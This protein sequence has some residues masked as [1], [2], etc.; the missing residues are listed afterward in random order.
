LGISLLRIV[1]LSI[2]PLFPCGVGAP[3]CTA[4]EFWVSF[5]L[6]TPTG[7]VG[8]VQV[9]V[10]H[11]IVCHGVNLLFYELHGKEVARNV[12]HDAAVGEARLVGDGALWQQGALVSEL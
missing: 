5:D 8:E 11:L 2:P 12:K 1:A 3:G 7:C 9:E 4:S 10:V 6:K